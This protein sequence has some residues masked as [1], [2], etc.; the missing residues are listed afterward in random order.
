MWSF[1]TL[2]EGYG[3]LRLRSHVDL[4]ASWRWV[5]CRN[6]QLLLLLL[7]LLLPP[8]LHTNLFVLRDLLGGRLPVVCRLCRFACPPISSP[9]LPLLPIPLLP[10]L[11]PSP[12]AY[13]TSGLP[14]FTVAARV[15]V[16]RMACDDTRLC[17]EG[18]RDCKMGRCAFRH[19]R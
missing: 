2:L 9:L 7:L 11:P 12:M 6:G 13:I 3:R 16:G 17:C 14:R 5:I 1:R 15:D 18:T 4:H 19:R 8:I 10:L